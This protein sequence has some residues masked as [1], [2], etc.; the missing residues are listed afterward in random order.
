[1]GA[2]EQ[3]LARW[4]EPESS[5]I[6]GRLGHYHASLI[7][8]ALGEHPDLLNGYREPATQTNGRVLV[9]LVVNA[10]TNSAEELRQRNE[11]LLASLAAGGRTLMSGATLVTEPELDVLVIDRASKGCELPNRQGVGLA[12]KIGA[13]IALALFTQQHLE[14][15][16]LY[17]TDA[18][19]KLPCDYFQRVIH[20]LDNRTGAWL[21][22]FLHDAGFDCGVYQ[23]TQLYELSIRYHVLGLAYAGSPYAYHSVGSALAIPIDSYVAVRG[24]PKRDAAEDFYLLD[25]LGKVSP[26]HRLSGTPIRLES[27]KSGRVPLGTGP[28][29]A[30]IMNEGNVLVAN[31]VAYEVLRVVLASLNDFALRRDASVFD[32]AF[33]GLPPPIA[34]AAG[35]ALC[36]FELPKA[37]MDAASRTG[38]RNLLRRIHCWF[39]ALRTL[40]FMHALRNA[41]I[42]DVS[43]Q[44]AIRSA[45]FVN[46]SGELD[47]ATG[48]AHLVNLESQLPAKVGASVVHSESL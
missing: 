24:V 11:V 20:Q 21:F 4:A 31:P 28:R 48:V 18:D 39:D 3:Y 25:K 23:A 36:K 12:R 41:G 30:R 32:R 8:P 10:G 9:I 14:Q 43:W 19:A 44:A 33:I 1:M 5:A 16:I 29:V 37:A 45:P 7:V 34:A 47:A 27:R 15:P 6:A 40:Q 2:A 17:F 38:Q 46:F 13:D 26:L 42:L 35:A 22:P